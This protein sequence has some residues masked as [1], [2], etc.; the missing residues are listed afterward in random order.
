MEAYKMGA[1]PSEPTPYDYSVKAMAPAALPNTWRRSRYPKIGKQAVSNCTNW[2]ASYSYEM[3]TGKR[4]SKGYLYGEREPDAYQGEGRYTKE[5]A[6]MML[7]YG[8]VLLNDYN[9]EFEVMQAQQHVKARQATLRKLAAEHKLDAYGRAYTDS[10]IKTALLAGHGVNFCGQCESFS[11]DK[12]GIY[13]MRAPKYGFHEMAI[14]DW[15]GSLFYCAQSWGTSFGK[16][17]FCWVPAEDVLAVRDILILD[18]HEGTK[19]DGSSKE[20]VIRRTLRKGMK[21]A[22]VEELQRKLL[23]L[24]YDLGK[25]GADGSFGTQTQTAAKL[26][27]KARGLVADGIVGPKTWEVLDKL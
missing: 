21:G 15:D 27:Q 26:F 9:Y 10:E 8:N 5:V 23:A 24:G 25:W 14:C 13:R 3:S 20:S 6:E 12:N 11:A 1:L 16:N 22:D 7:K 4:F 17:G 2:A 18:F 19:D